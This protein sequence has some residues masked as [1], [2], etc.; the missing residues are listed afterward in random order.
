MICFTKITFFWKKE[1]I[2]LLTLMVCLDDDLFERAELD[3]VAEHRVEAATA[4]HVTD[5]GEHAPAFLQCSELLH[6]AVVEFLHEVIPVLAAGGST[7]VDLPQQR[8]KG[9]RRLRRCQDGSFPD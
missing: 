8:D 4:F 7:R 3:D 9:I 5:Q 6:H 2:Q 1:S